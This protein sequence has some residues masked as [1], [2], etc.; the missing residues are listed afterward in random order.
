MPSIDNTV[1]E[2]FN[3]L[4]QRHPQLAPAMESL[5]ASAQGKSGMVSVSATA[6]GP[7]QAFFDSVKPVRTNLAL[8]RIGGETD[9]GYLVPDD[10]EG[11][12]TCFSPGVAATA[13][14]ELELAGRGIRSYMAD[15]SVEEEP[16]KNPLFHFEKKYLGTRNDAVYTTLDAWVQKNA[17]PE[18]DL[19]LQMD[20]EGAEYAVL[21]DAA[22]S[23]LARFRIL[24]VEFHGLEQLIQQK[25]FELI[26][27][28]FE[29]LLRDFEVLH[30]H[31]NNCL[32]TFSYLGFEIP[33]VLEFTFCRKDRIQER[34]PATQFPHPLDRTNV[35]E[36]ADYALPACWHG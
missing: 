17:P 2:M 19:L 3:H 34:T 35:P 31:P 32:K 15:Y 33:P 11:I 13:N 26:N 4:L 9:G 30:I 21:L 6:A 23:T 12:S 25:G 28:A 22:P 16:I 14:F 24:V 27:Q 18:G 10:L 7:L 36:F 20:I 1:L 29:K 8:L 5:A